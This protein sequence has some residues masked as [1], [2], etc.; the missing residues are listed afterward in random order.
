[1]SIPFA[2]QRFGGFALRFFFVLGVLLP[3]G[4]QARAAGSVDYRFV[5]VHQF[6]QFGSAAPVEWT[7]KPFLL[8]AEL[9][10]G[11]GP[12][13]T[14]A[15]LRRPGGAANRLSVNGTR[16]AFTAS[17]DLAAEL[18]AA[19]PAAATGYGLAVTLA[20]T[21]ERVLPLAQGVADFP[22]APVLA[23]LGELDGV[24]PAG[25]P[26]LLRWQTPGDGGRPDFIR[27]V[28]EYLNGEETFHTPGPG[29]VGVLDGGRSEFL[30]PGTAWAVPA[31][32]VGGAPVFLVR[33][34]FL[35]VGLIDTEAV[36][37]AVGYSGSASATSSMV[38]LGT[39][40]VRKD[41]LDFAAFQGRA[42]VQSG[43]ESAAL[44]ADTPLRFE[45]GAAG[46][47]SESLRVVTLGLPTGRKAELAR[48]VGG[49]EF[50]LRAGAATL[51]EF[52]AIYAP[53]NYDF[54][55]E[56]ADEGRVE[57]RLELSRNPADF[58][59]AALLR[60]YARAQVLDPT[61]GIT[62]EMSSWADES[63]DDFS[64]VILTT[65]DGTIVEASTPWPGR[66]H[67]GLLDLDPNRLEHGRTYLCRMR[68]FRVNLHD[69]SAYPG[70]SGWAGLFTETVCPVQTVPSPDR[71]SIVS[72]TRLVL[73]VGVEWIRWLEVEGGQ[74]PL[75]WS[76]VQGATPKGLDFDTLAGRFRGWPAAPGT[77]G[78]RVRVADAEG[79]VA[80][81]DLTFEITGEVKRLWVD[82]TNLPPALGDTYYL[83]G[84]ATGGGVLPVRWSLAPGSGPLPP[85]LVLDPEHGLVHGVPAQAGSFPFVARATDGSGQVADRGLVLVVPAFEPS[86]ELSIARIETTPAGRL[87]VVGRVEPGS[88]CTVEGSMDLKDWVSLAAGVGLEAGGIELAVPSSDRVV[89]LR[90]RRGPAEPMLRPMSATL[91][92]DTNRVAI[93]M[94]DVA[95]GSMSLTNAEGTVLRLELPAGAVTEPTEVRMTS[96]RGMEGAPLGGGWIG[97]AHLEPD[98]LV[99]RKAATLTIQSGAPLGT[100]VVAMGYEGEGLDLHEEPAFV[101]DRTLRIPVLHFCGHGAGKPRGIDWDRIAASMGGSCRASSRAQSR[102]AELIR[103]GLADPTPD[104]AIPAGILRDIEGVFF[105][106]W[107]ETVLPFVDA[108]RRDETMLS[109]AVNEYL[110]WAKQLDI[111]LVGLPSVTTDFD[112]LHRK[113]RAKA[114]RGALN[115]INK[116]HAKAVTQHVFSSAPAQML[117]IAT[118]AVFLDL[119]QELPGWLDESAIMERI[120]RFWRFELSM[121]AD[122]TSVGPEGM[123]SFSVATEGAVLGL[124]LEPGSADRPLS[125]GAGLGV[126]EF[127]PFPLQRLHFRSKARNGSGYVPVKAGGELRFHH[128]RFG[129]NSP[130][131]AGS[132]DPG[133]S[134]GCP[135]QHFKKQREPAPPDAMILTLSFDDPVRAVIEGSPP[136]DLLIDDL[137]GFH[138]KEYFHDPGEKVPD[139]FR[140]QEKWVLTWRQLVAQAD[141]NPPPRTGPRGTVTETTSF[142]LKHAPKPLRKSDQSVPPE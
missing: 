97:G 20:G 122:L 139:F 64:Q 102:I 5:K 78:L 13:I 9:S 114:A 39:P 31:A 6:V 142:T 35:R 59:P 68:R 62:L 22:A 117:G 15:E 104:G 23:N 108:A 77:S 60:D 55:F 90:V 89:F 19:Y 100:N 54:I 34:E 81:Q 37:G 141:Y 136:V 14:S 46:R 84:L 135:R 92:R 67:G 127:T 96:L 65:M 79:R 8:R 83:A 7:P 116:L 44:S 74:P 30:V 16:A 115:A 134:S 130:A 51:A 103:K 1:M 94:V 106:W 105:E 133:D 137:K 38:S 24:H 27:V 107:G 70:V 48:V 43:P 99:L 29:E 21:Q 11:A 80:E 56:T 112:A 10:S 87:R 40:V 132:S 58:P 75:V 61:K 47:T 52:D 126:S 93:V 32:S 17:F 45:A 53:G 12:A 86:P 131:D 33:V 85:G 69:V 36:P 4:L 25:E 113:W 140:F 28:V 88:V 49:P 138:D 111:I 98:G 121:R 124:S 82:P 128:L 41:V 26:F 57:A 125:F 63:G 42:F 76:V 50:W 119:V 66:I 18:E 118:E 120:A 3:H 95:G 110:L 71:M 109:L 72:P 73:P 91:D 101:S 2:V 123:V 129:W